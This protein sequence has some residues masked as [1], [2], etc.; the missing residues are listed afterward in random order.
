MKLYSFDEGGSNIR[1]VRN[2]FHG[3]PC[4]TPRFPWHPLH[5]RP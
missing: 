2:S 5:H 3:N 1:L 4:F